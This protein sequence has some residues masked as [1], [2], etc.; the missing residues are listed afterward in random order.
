MSEDNRRPSRVTRV[1][2]FFRRVFGS[3]LCSRASRTINDD[4]P[5]Q[6]PATNQDNNTATECKAPAAHGLKIDLRA[7]SSTNEATTLAAAAAKRHSECARDSLASWEIPESELHVD[8]SK[9]LGV[10]TF[11]TVY[12]GE[13]RP[14]GKV[15]VKYLHVALFDPD[16]NK[17]RDKK[18]QCKL[19][20]L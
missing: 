14:H 1:R 4:A 12:T 19:V 10:G 20:K 8:K 16:E 13:Y 5:A 9:T 2:V 7:C 17:L 15:A 6:A 3:L 18:K 11:G